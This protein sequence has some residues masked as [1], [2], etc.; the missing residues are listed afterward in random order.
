MAAPEYDLT[1]NQVASYQFE[2][3]MTDAT[4]NFINI[5]SWSLCGS[6]APNYYEAP[7]TQWNFSITSAV[8]GAVTAYLL[9]SQ[10]SLLSSSIPVPKNK[11]QYVYDILAFNPTVSPPV[12]TRLFQGN[13]FVS[14]GVTTDFGTD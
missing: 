9:P 8:S 10:S 6:I 12:M 4:G 13:I 2:F 11:A 5:T 3:V 1:I 14:P 7:V